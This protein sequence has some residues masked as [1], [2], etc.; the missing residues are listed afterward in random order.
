[1]F[2]S[3]SSEQSSGPQAISHQPAA[4]V[5][6]EEGDRVQITVQLGVVI[7]AAVPLQLHGL[8]QEGL[9]PPRGQHHG[10]WQRDAVPLPSHSALA[11]RS[12]EWLHMRYLEEDTEEK[13]KHT[14]RNTTN[15]VRRSAALVMI[16]IMTSVLGTT[17]P[18]RGCF[19]GGVSRRK[20]TDGSIL[21]V[22]RRPVETLLSAAQM[23]DR[24]NAFAE[25]TANCALIRSRSR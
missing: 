18:E 23:M 22:Q 3:H 7:E 2:Q 16:N 1:M 6:E 21:S 11:F 4:D 9:H 10:R 24:G 19:I 14:V 12:S 13:K 20:Y 15:I 25:R 17:L 8:P 5:I